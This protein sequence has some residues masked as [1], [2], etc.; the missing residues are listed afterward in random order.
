MDLDAL[1]AAM[2]EI[3][4]V[5][6]DAAVSY[7]KPGAGGKIMVH[8]VLTLDLYKITKPNTTTAPHEVYEVIMPYQSG[9]PRLAGGDDDHLESLLVD[10]ED[11]DDSTEHGFWVLVRDRRVQ[12][13]SNLILLHQAGACVSKKDGS[14]NMRNVAPIFLQAWGNNW[15]YGVYFLFGIVKVGNNRVMK[16]SSATYPDGEHVHGMLYVP[17]KEFTLPNVRV[18][19]SGSSDHTKLFFQSLIRIVAG[20]GALDWTEKDVREIIDSTKDDLKAGFFS[21]NNW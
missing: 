9:T 18:P 6:L 13:L 11:A 19:G 5:S 15:I 7:K 1:R 3:I 14:A 17:R 2:E 16:D 20:D 12:G 8:G 10:A 4:D 21:E